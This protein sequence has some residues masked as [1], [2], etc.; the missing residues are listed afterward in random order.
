L[1]EEWCIPKVGAEFVWRMEELLDLYMQP[2]DEALPVVCIDER[3]C[4]LIGHLQPPEPPQPGRPARE[5]TE[6]S[7]NGGCSTFLMFEPRAGWRHALVKE[8][9]TKRDFADCLKYL[10]DDKYASA[11]KVRL[12]LDNLNTHTPAALYETFPFPEALR[13]AKK[14]EWHY[15]PLHGSWLNMVEIELSVLVNQCLKRRIGAIEQLREEI[16]AWE[17]AR[18]AQRAIVQWRFTPADAR[19]KL[20]HLYPSHEEATS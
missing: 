15:T 19:I 13:L 14:I 11:S 12:V 3:P 6:F 10:L 5:D 1:K 8:T 17:Q 20:K 4:Q 18:N 2:Y 7:R 16:T 9:R